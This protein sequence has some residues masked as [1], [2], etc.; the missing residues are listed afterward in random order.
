MGTI[1]LPKLKGNPMNQLNERS[2]AIP[3]P[4][5]MRHLPIA[6]SGYVVPWFVTRG[7]DGSYD[8]RAADM[9]K[10]K[11]AV[12]QK[13]CWLCGQTLGRHLA[14]VIGPMCVVNRVTSEP[15]SHLECAEYAVKACPFLSQPKMRRN[16][17]GM[18]EMLESGEAIAP[19][20]EHFDRN[21]G[22]CAIYITLT[23]SAFPVGQGKAGVLFRLG[24]P[25]HVTYYREGRL[26]TRA[27][28][29]E[30]IDS[31]MPT[32]REMAIGQGQEAMHAL[33]H[34]YQRALRLL[35]AA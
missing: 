20:G 34:Q 19:P 11:R 30:S 9:R 7:D 2:L 25:E 3:I 17:K 29:L 32:L 31:G 13:L 1:K 21:P 10:H 28:V 14:F 33:Q 8:F 15:P 6:D 26:A 35:P 5:R 18:A 12:H 22:A 23:Y 27:E 16:A 24:E 4:R